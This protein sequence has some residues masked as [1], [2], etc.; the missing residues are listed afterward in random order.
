MGEGSAGKSSDIDMT[1][2]YPDKKPVQITSRQTGEVRL[3]EPAQVNQPRYTTTQRMDTEAKE[4]VPTSALASTST[5]DAISSPQ[6]HAEQVPLEPQNS[7]ASTASVAKAKGEKKPKVEI[8]TLEQFIQ[9]AYD[10]K[11]KWAKL[12]PKAEKSLAESVAQMDGAAMQRLLNL[13]ADDKLLLV[14]RQLLLLSGD[15][16]GFPAL[17]AALQ[18]FVLAVMQHPPVFAEP[19]IQGV[20]RNLPDAITPKEA[21]ARVA[22]FS[23]TPEG[24][25]VD[26][27]ETELPALQRNAT[28][29]LITWLAIH[30]SMSLDKVSALLFEAVWQPAAQQIADK[31]ARLRALTEVEQTAGA[32]LA[33]QQFRD[34][35]IDARSSQD[36]ALREASALR[37]RLAET[38]IQQQLAEEQ[39]DALQAELVAL[40][41]SAATELVKRQ[42]QHDIDCTHLRNDQEKL[43]GRLLRRLNEGVEMLEVGLSAL[44]NK[45]P[46]VEVMVE[47]AEYV[48]DALRVDL[49]HLK[50]K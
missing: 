25:Q 37:S 40:R 31:N 12:S 10:R 43:R 49:N 26:W 9:H 13:A 16:Q 11:G 45:T 39:R 33:C 30:R 50:E 17:R 41:E 21:L 42:A 27:K 24:D 3:S 5:K 32:G 29:L 34:Q 47:R 28:Q 19:R 46:R 38:Q 48:V 22:S 2:N 6:T 7:A 35:A 4:D 15:I 8:E 1:K 23:L 18:D 14:P 36:H 20:L 44:R